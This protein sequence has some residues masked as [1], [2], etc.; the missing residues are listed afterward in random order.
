MEIIDN[1][2]IPIERLFFYLEEYFGVQHLS[3]ESAEFRK[4]FKRIRCSENGYWEISFKKFPP[5]KLLLFIIS[6]FKSKLAHQHLSIY[7]NAENNNSY[8]KNSYYE[9]GKTSL[10]DFLK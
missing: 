10:A 7:L 3:N 1:G 5:Q 2:T 8:P 9:E 6:L 4:E